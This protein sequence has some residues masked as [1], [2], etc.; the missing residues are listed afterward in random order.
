MH[1]ACV[2]VCRGRGAFSRSTKT[3]KHA[4]KLALSLSLCLSDSRTPPQRL[5]NLIFHVCL[6]ATDGSDWRRRWG[7]GVLA[8]PA[9]QPVRLPGRRAQPNNRTRAQPCADCGMRSCHSSG[10][11]GTHTHTLDARRARRQRATHKQQPIVP[12][13]ST[14]S[15]DI[16]N[17]RSAGRVEHVRISLVDIF[18]E[19]NWGHVCVCVC[20]CE[21]GSWEEG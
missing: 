21:C 17:V 19:A 7:R 10:V 1:H 13:Q 8:I 15:S 11:T 14:K 3:H 6:L 18:G 16:L 4:A 12:R 5:A 9:A 2:C 20:V